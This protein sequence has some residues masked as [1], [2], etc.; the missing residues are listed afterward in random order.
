LLNKDLAILL[1]VKLGAII[2][3]LI[4]GAH[5]AANDLPSPSIAPLALEITVWLGK[6]L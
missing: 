4:L 2:L 5:S 6:P 1:S 3:T